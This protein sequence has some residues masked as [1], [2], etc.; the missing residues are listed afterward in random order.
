MSH[1]SHFVTTTVT[2]FSRTIALTGN[3]S[4]LALQITTRMRGELFDWGVG[5]YDAVVQEQ[6]F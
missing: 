1:M 4:S 5:I 3:V 2:H 6:H